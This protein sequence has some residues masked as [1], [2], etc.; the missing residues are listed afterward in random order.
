MLLIFLPHTRIKTAL[1]H[2]NMP[3][4]PDEIAMPKSALF[5]KV[6]TNIPGTM[7]SIKFATSRI[8][9]PI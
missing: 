8:A 3:A 9:R 1:K 4:M 5:V 2:D 7:H 6:P